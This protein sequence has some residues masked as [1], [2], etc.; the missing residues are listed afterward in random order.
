[1]RVRQRTRQQVRPSPCWAGWLH[2]E[3]LDQDQDQRKGTLWVSLDQIVMVSERENRAGESEPPRP[4]PASSRTRRLAPSPPTHMG[5]VRPCAPGAQL[6]LMILGHR[7]L[8]HLLA[9]VVGVTVLPG[10]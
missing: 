9:H 10:G 1:M 2:P 5:R 7:L 4:R 6:A 8:V 3:F